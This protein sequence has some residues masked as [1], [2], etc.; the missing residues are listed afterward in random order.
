MQTTTI[1]TAGIVVTNLPA[2]PGIDDWSG[3]SA[4]PGTAPGETATLDPHLNGSW[5]ANWVSSWIAEAPADLR[6]TW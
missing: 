3:A 1:T 6:R 5:D 2:D 4:W